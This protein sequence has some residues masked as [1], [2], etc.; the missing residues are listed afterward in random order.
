[1]GPNPADSRLGRPE[2]P[3]VCRAGQDDVT[4]PGGPRVEG[5]ACSGEFFLRKTD[6]S[7]G[8]RVPCAHRGGR[9]TQ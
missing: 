1:M 9:K 5:F 7:V 8:G 3:L 4:K 2:S 6:G